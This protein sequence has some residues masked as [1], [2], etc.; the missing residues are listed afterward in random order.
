MGRVVR[1]RRSWRQ[2]KGS[3]AS[4]QPRIVSVTEGLV[5]L[6]IALVFCVTK[7]IREVSMKLTTNLKVI[8]APSPQYS[9]KEQAMSPKYYSSLLTYLII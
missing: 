5:A 7:D 6:E 1:N 9:L 8:A 3:W 2:V 4:H